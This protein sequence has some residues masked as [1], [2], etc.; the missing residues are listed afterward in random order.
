MGSAKLWVGLLVFAIGVL[1]SGMVAAG[2][3]AYGGVP[4]GYDKYGVVAI[5]GA[6][7]VDLPDGRV[8]L[9][10]ANSVSQCTADSSRLNDLPAGTSVRITPA[11][12]GDPLEIT[13]IPDWLYDFSTNCRGHEPYGRIDVPDAGL[14]LVETT[15]AAKRS[16]PRP[17]ARRPA[18][19][20]GGADST[21]AR[22][23][24]SAPRRGHRSAHRSQARSCC[25][26]SARRSPPCRCSS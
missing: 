12:G 23:S 25:S 18:L 4:H 15:H 8:M 11:D 20:T 21:S 17:R 1:G 9:D 2:W 6:A 3:F 7:V 16:A 19:P 5:P 22:G 10:H 24:P 14:Y 26:C 13:S